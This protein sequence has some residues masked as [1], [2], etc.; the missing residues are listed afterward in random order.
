M[1]DARELLQ[2]LADRNLKLGSVESLT[3][4]LFGSTVCEVPGASMV[5]RGGLITYDPALKVSLANVSAKDIDEEGVVSAKVATEMA[6][7]GRKALGCD[8]CVSCTGNAGP[9]VQKGGQPV[10]TVFLGLAYQG[11]VWTVPLHLQGT[12]NEIRKATVDAMIAFAASLFPVA[13]GEGKK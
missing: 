8:V 13:P 12:R 3:A 2:R 7:G 1:I 4:G 9:D 5:Y 11:N 6:E 10:G